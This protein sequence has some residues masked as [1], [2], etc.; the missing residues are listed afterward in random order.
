M[1]PYQKASKAMQT[2]GLSPINV[3]SGAIGAATTLA[4]GGIA[5]KVLQKALPFLSSFISP[6][7]AMKGLSKLDPRLK[8][9]I[10][11]AME[12]GKPFEEVKDFISNKIDQ[13]I[14]KQSDK[15]ER[16]DKTYGNFFQGV[17]KKLI[18]Q[19]LSPAQ[20]AVRVKSST[21]SN[22]AFIKSMEEGYGMDLV[23]IID[24]IFGSNSQALPEVPAQQTAPE[25]Q[26]ALQSQ[27]PMQQQQAPGQGQQALMGILQ[28]IAQAR[29]IQ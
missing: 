15:R 20:A 26:A 27:A 18:D 2:Q 22:K 16:L 12:N 7:E 9:F 25:S 14:P 21:S 19:G 29:G 17:V 3:G 8:D 24:S 10:G 1:Q 6:E 4:G 11:T 23:D 28:K 13:A 5:S